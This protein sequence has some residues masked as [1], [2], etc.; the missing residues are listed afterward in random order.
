MSAFIIAMFCRNFRQAQTAC[1]QQPDDIIKTL[2]QHLKDPENPLL[3]QWTCFLISMLWH[4]FPE[5]IWKG[6][7]ESTHQRLCE[8]A[9]D[10]V[11]EVRAAAI[12]ALNNFMG[13][14]DITD[15]IRQHEESIASAILPMT[16]D[17]NCMVR[18]ELLVFFSTFVARY[19]SKFLVA[20]H[21]QLLSERDKLNNIGATSNGHQRGPSTSSAIEDDGPVS[22]NSIQASVWAHILT[23]T[24]DAHPEIAQ[25]ASTIV[26]YIHEAL[27][28]SPLGTQTRTVMDEMSRVP[29]RAPALSRQSST[30]PAP[31]ATQASASPAPNPL[32]RNESYLSLGMRR[33]ASVAAALKFLT[34]GGAAAQNGNANGS[35]RA[36]APNGGPQMVGGPRARVPAEWSRP[37]DEKDNTSNSV[38]YASAK[39]PKTRGF[40]ARSPTEKPVV[41]LQSGLFD[42]A[43]EVA[44]DTFLM[45]LMLL[46]NRI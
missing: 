25:D 5:A 39:I 45:L 11:P 21:E 10:P 6:I 8:I 14:P 15:M 29:R 19:Q 3:R 24:V 2:N 31:R 41:P 22:R 34:I 13:I 27:L 32:Q 18:R 23:M 9:L 36:S 17:G 1:L 38:A 20:A 28:Q 7:K 26:D 16:S 40:K 35:N 30:A 4:N 46:L 33:T 43:I 37:P 44:D 42:W 12:Y